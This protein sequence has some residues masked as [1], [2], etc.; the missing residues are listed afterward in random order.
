[1]SALGQ[2]RTHAAQQKQHCYSIISSARP[3]TCSRNSFAERV[4]GIEAT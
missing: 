2:K 1:M 4:Y 3:N